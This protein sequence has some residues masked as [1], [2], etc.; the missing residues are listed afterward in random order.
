MGCATFDAAT[1]NHTLTACIVLVGCTTPPGEPTFRSAPRPIAFVLSKQ[2]ERIIDRLTIQAKGLTRE[3][4][5]IHMRAHPR[6]TFE[7]LEA[8]GKKGV[9]T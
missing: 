8:I 4:N 3:S 7:S 6:D 9:I 1:P 2:H 5:V